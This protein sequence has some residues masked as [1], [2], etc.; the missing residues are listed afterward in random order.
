M[1]LKTATGQVAFQ[2]QKNGVFT[3]RNIHEAHG[4]SSA[5]HEIQQINSGS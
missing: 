5:L 4:Q 2:Y 1:K 3:T